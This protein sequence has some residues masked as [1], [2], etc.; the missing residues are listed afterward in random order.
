MAKIIYPKKADGRGPWLIDHEQLIE[1]NE[2]IDEEFHVFEEYRDK[3]IKDKVKKELDAHKAVT[4]NEE[5]FDAEQIATEFR[6]SDDLKI[7]K[8][9]TIDFES[10]KR[11]Y[12]D[13]LIEATKVPAIE[14]D[15]VSNLLIEIRFKNYNFSIEF[16][17][18]EYGY[19]SNYLFIKIPQLDIINAQNIHNKIEFWKKKYQPPTWQRIWFYKI[20]KIA[21]VLI[22]IFIALVIVFL[23]FSVDSSRRDEINDEYKELVKG[24]VQKEE[25]TKALELLLFKSFESEL[26]NDFINVNFNSVYNNKILK[27]NFYLIIISCILMFRPKFQIAIGKGEN[28]VKYWKFYIKII[29]I[30]LPGAI[31]IDLILTLS[32]TLM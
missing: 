12:V 21:S 16:K 9:I 6:Q 4:G 2:L 25:E 15:L 26:A 29:F 28:Y 17:D 32:N 31:I 23:S 11:M 18:S 30:T 27:F 14:D 1:L 8:Q 3:I 22:F 13:N 19:K 7:R 24:G 5:G 20:G 10:G